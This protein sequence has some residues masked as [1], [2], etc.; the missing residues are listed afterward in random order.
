MQQGHNNTTCTKQLFTRAESFFQVLVRLN[1]GLNL[2]LGHIQFG[3]DQSINRRRVEHKDRIIRTTVG[4][5]HIE[6]VVE[7]FTSREVIGS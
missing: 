5:A 2:E 1:K 4:T 6:A 3:S 7:E